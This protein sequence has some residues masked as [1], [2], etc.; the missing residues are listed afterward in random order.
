MRVCVVSGGIRERGR[1]AAVDDCRNGRARGRTQTEARL[2]RVSGGYPI[3]AVSGGDRTSS[4]S[5]E[6]SFRFGWHLRVRVI[7]LSLIRSVTV[8]A[9]SRGT[10]CATARCGRSAWSRMLIVMHLHVKIFVS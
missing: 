2:A 10:T 6:P 3:S 4:S 1:G 8:L 9:A 7:G 5:P